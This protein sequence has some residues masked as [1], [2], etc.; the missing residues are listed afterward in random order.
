MQSSVRHQAASLP[1]TGQS[2]SAQR[3]PSDIDSQTEIITMNIVTLRRRYHRASPTTCQFRTR[4]P[5][6]DSCGWIGRSVIYSETDGMQRSRRR[7]I[8]RYRA[9]EIHSYK[10]YSG[11]G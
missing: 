5:K 2:M 7:E 4:G 3:P 6:A 11:P 9:C 1:K 8:E 10:F